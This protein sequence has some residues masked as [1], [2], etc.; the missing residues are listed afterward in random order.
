MDH[1]NHSSW[2]KNW[3]SEDN[4]CPQYILNIKVWKWI[5]YFFVLVLIVLLRSASST[6][7]FLVIF[8]DVPFVKVFRLQGSYQCWSISGSRGIHHFLMNGQAGWWTFSDQW[9]FFSCLFRRQLGARSLKVP[10]SLLLL[11][12]HF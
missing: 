7:F 6:F 5:V 10:T 4:L 8:S 12:Q 11:S 1:L 2:P 9:E 3:D